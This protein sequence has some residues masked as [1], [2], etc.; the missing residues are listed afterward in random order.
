MCRGQHR[1]KLVLQWA[2]NAGQSVRIRKGIP[3]CFRLF[4]IQHERAVIGPSARCYGV[5]L[6]VQ[7]AAVHGSQVD[8]GSVGDG[9]LRMPDAVVDDFVPN[10]PLYRITAGLV[11]DN[12]TD[13]VGTA[14]PRGT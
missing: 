14:I 3:Q 8:Q 2:R 5:S 10:Q 4:V 6:S 1:Q 13:H 9:R 12:H 7:L 11:T